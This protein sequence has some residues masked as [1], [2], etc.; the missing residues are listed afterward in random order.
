MS[1]CRVL[2][3]PANHTTVLG[4]SE[5]DFFCYLGIKALPNRPSKFDLKFL[6]VIIVISQVTLE[7]HKFSSFWG[8]DV[9]KAIHFPSYGGSARSRTSRYYDQKWLVICNL[10]ISNLVPKPNKLCVSKRFC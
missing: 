6:R 4:T 2:K 9:S 5:D 1:V 8:D 3:I 7:T 10:A